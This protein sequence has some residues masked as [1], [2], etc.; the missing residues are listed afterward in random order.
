MQSGFDSF[1]HLGRLVQ[2][3]KCPPTRGTKCSQ[4]SLRIIK[5]MNLWIA[6]V[7]ERITEI[8]LAEPRGRL[9]CYN[10]RVTNEKLLGERGK[11]PRFFHAFLRPFLEPGEWSQREWARAEEIKSGLLI[12]WPQNICTGVSGRGSFAFQIFCNPHMLS[13]RA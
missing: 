1:Q 6:Y 12:E 10:L 11:N 5:N 2:R 8:G 7:V 13:F 4:K 3:K 9:A